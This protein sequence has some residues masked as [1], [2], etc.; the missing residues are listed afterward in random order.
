M[1]FLIGRNLHESEESP[2][3]GNVASKG[4]RRRA[5]LILI[6][7]QVGVKCPPSVALLFFV[8]HFYSFLLFAKALVL[9]WPSGKSYV[10]DV[11]ILM[12]T[13]VRTEWILNGL[14]ANSS[15]RIAGDIRPNILPGER[16]R[17]S[18][19]ATWTHGTVHSKIDLIFIDALVTSKQ[20]SWVA[21]S[22]CV[23]VCC[24][25]CRDDSSSI[26]HWNYPRPHR[27]VCVCVCVSIAA[28]AA[29]IT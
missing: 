5:L 1:G 3:W 11:R 13:D 14:P 12:A 28:N 10:I 9:E 26:L 19:I 8:S 4:G 25:Q 2:M 15:P 23:H 22:E 6:I 24:T 18:C 7:F 29:T 20:P 21:L 27:R 16:N 17:E